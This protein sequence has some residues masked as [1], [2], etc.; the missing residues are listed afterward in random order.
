[1]IHPLLDFVLPTDCVACGRALDARQRMGVCSSCWCGFRPVPRPVCPACGLPRSEFSDLLGPARG[2]CATCLASE[3]SLD[4]VRA[5]VVY[6]DLARSVVLEAKLGRR[7]ELFRP[8]GDLM[9]A[10]LRASGFACGALAL[11]P[12]PSHPLSDLRRGFSPSNELARRLARALELPLLR[13]AVVRRWLPLGSAKRL[14]RRGRIS[15]VERAYRSRRAPV[16]SRLLLVDDV[17]TTGATLEACAAA[18]KSAG[19]TDVRGVIWARALPPSW[20]S[21]RSR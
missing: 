7:P 21:N 8:I 15:F 1:V 9:A 19:A 10:D 5:V 3:R 18:L 14:A 13:G 4:A 2:L 11:V 16:P 6:D 12:V 20:H 17:M